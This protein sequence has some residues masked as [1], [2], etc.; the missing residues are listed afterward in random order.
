[1]EHTAGAI[2]HTVSAIHHPLSAPNHPLTATSGDQPASGARPRFTSLSF[3]SEQ[4]FSLRLLF[5]SRIISDFVPP[6]P[7]SVDELSSVGET[8]GQKVQIFALFGDSPGIRK[9]RRGALT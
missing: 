3:A 5:I 9:C 7:W 6:R 1:M 4:V 8:C 2:H